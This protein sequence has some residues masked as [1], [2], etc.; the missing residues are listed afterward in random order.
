MNCDAFMAELDD[1]LD[2]DLP[3]GQ[4][5]ALELHAARCPAC[6]RALDGATRLRQRAQALPVTLEPA[7][8]LWPGIAAQLEERG[9]GRSR[10]PAWLRAVAAS[11]AVLMVFAGGMLADR[12]LQENGKD[13]QP[14]LAAN[15]LPSAADARR[16]LPASY[17][18]LIEGSGGL[19]AGG[20]E[21]DLLR[22]LL[23]VNLA[24]REVEAALADS[25]DDAGLRK[26]LAGLYAEE[27]RILAQAQRLRTAQRAP[28]RTAI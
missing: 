21:Q 28:T 4:A 24:I 1:Y 16:I 15:S 26:L 18:E 8:D 9:R 3:A 14:R 10:R 11:V 17:V 7:R 23:V 5:R 13:A 20:V 25:A 2:G 12:V 6:G 22:N 19:D 27:N